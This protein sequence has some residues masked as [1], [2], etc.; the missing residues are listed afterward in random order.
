MLWV[1]LGWQFTLAEYVG[2][3]VMIVLMWVLLRL[4]VRRA[5]G[6]TRA[7]TPSAA[8]AGHQHHSAA[9]A[10]CAGASG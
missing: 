8:D 5:G 4:F 9:S 1:L 2:G 10:S 3:V 7:S 6:A